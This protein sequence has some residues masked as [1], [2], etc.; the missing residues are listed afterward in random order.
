MIGLTGGSASG[1]SSVGRRLETV[2]WGVVDCDKPGHMAYTPDQPA[3]T[4]LVQEFGQGILA[5][6]GNID[7]RALGGIQV[8]AD[9]F[10]QHCVA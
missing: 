2:G 4:R 5:A 6:D 10:Q 3:H 7:R 8:Q 1:K 9:D